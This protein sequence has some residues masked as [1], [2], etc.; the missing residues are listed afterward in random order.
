MKI[1]LTNTNLVFRKEKDYVDFELIWRDLSTATGSITPVV[2]PGD[3]S[4][5]TTKVKISVE[6]DGVS[7]LPNI[8]TGV[9]D[10]GIVYLY[11]SAGNYIGYG[12]FDASAFQN[13]VAISN[14]LNV[15]STYKDGSNITIDKE[16]A[17]ANAKSYLVGLTKNQSFVDSLEG[18]TFKIR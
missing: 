8:G 11:D 12:Q 3:Y 1:I 17:I 6:E 18:K 16:T 5:V 10:S 15:P 4:R 7:I 9:S 13:G 14:I 2:E